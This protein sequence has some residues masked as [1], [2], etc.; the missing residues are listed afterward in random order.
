MVMIAGLVYLLLM[1][2]VTAVGCFATARRG[3]LG[4]APLD[5]CHDPR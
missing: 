5:L 1:D 3:H 4:A 2:G